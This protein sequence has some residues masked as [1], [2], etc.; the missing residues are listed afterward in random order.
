MI[1][2]VTSSAQLTIRTTQAMPTAP[3]T[4]ARAGDFMAQPPE[5]ANGLMIARLLC[6]RQSWY[7]LASQVSGTVSGRGGRRRQ[8]RGVG[9]RAP[10]LRS[11]AK[12]AQR[13]VEPAAW[14]DT[15]RVGVGGRCSVF[16]CSVFGP[17]KLFRT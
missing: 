4:M 13:L 17:D 15:G 7:N 16:R 9:D 12:C 2:P 11:G 5:R 10:A 3:T 1:R 14:R 6:R 8:E